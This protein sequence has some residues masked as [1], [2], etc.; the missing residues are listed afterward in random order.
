MINDARAIHAG[1]KPHQ[2]V[3]KNLSKMS[4]AGTSYNYES[5]IAMVLSGHYI[6]FLPEAVAQPHIDSGE[7]RA[8]RKDIKS[9]PL[10]VAVICK[11]AI[12]K[13]RAKELFLK[14]IAEVFDDV[15]L[16]RP[17]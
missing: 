8:L 12:N 11:K 10:G 17:Y 16:Q 15:E 1:L 5:R 4:L 14:A 6:C 9:F 2:E 3:Y 13:N 7:L